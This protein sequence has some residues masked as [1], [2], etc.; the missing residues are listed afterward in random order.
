[1][2]KRN[3]WLAAGAIGAGLLLWFKRD[4]KQPAA[5]PPLE[6]SGPRVVVLGA[7]FAGLTAAQAGRSPE[8]PGP[9]FAH[10]PP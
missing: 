6:T 1:M 8:R 4:R 3:L 9:H 5:V 10:R 2:T 7:G